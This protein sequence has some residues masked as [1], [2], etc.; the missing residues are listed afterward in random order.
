VG[1]P[2]LVVAVNVSNEN[3]RSDDVGQRGV[4]FVQRGL[5]VVDGT[6][7]LGVRVADADDVAPVVGRRRPE[8]S[9]RSSTRTARE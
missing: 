9:I 7:S 2:Y 3:A 8:T 1:L 4:E 6:R 5:D